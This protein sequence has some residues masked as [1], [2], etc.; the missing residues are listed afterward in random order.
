MSGVVHTK[1]KRADKN[2]I[3]KF[4]KIPASIVSDAMN[5]MNSMSADINPIIENVHVAGSA[6][7]VQCMVGDNIMVHKAI[8]IAEPGDVIVIDSKGHTHSSVWGSIMTKAS[9]MRGIE[10]VVIDGAIRDIN[11]NRKDSFPIYCKGYVPG[12]SQKSWGGN[13]NMPIHCGGVSINPGDIIVGDDDGIVVVPLDMAEIV[14]NKSLETLK[15]E[16]EWIKKIEEGKTTLEAIGLDKK[17]N[18]LG[19]NIKD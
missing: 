4:K 13:I 10:A 15:K 17:F 18:D 11:D 12:G 19:I 3:N 8:Y 5:R 1:I 14:L 7:T 9:K 2:L 6:I 16:K